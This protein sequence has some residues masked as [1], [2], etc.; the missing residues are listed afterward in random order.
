MQATKSN[1]LKQFNLMQ[2]GPYTCPEKIMHT[3]LLSFLRGNELLHCGHHGFTPGKSTLTNMLTFDAYIVNCQLFKHSYD[4]MS[5]DLKKNRKGAT[6]K[7]FC[8][9]SKE[10]LVGR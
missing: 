8:W 1:D 7:G 5:I 6:P 2:M 10:L 9:Q 4:I 3:Q